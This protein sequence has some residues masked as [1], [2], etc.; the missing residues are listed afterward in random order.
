MLP[1]QARMCAP[2]E[3]GSSLGYLVYPALADHES[4]QIR[5]RSPGEFEFAFFGGNPAAPV[6]LFTLHYDLPAGGI[7]VWSEDLSYRAPDCEQSEMEIGQITRRAPP[8][9]EPVGP[10]R[11]GCAARRG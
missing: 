1:Q 10:A 11:S 5:R 7:G 2:L 4:F 8:H 6:H 9:G 3:A